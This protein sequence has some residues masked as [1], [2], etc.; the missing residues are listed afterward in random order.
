MPWVAKQANYLPS[1]LFVSSKVM[2]ISNYILDISDEVL[3]TSDKL[4]NTLSGIN[5]VYN[6]DLSPPR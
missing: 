2:Y 4:Y 3:Y 1:T 6:Y 5:L